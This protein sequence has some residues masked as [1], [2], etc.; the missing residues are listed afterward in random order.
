MNAVALVDC[1]NFFVSCER[2][3]R[4]ELIGRPVVVLSGNDGCVISRSQEAKA[5]G[6]PMGVPFFE[7]RALAAEHDIVILSGN[8]ELYGD[9]S[10][11]VMMTLAD[12]SPE[13]EI[14][15]IDE[16]FLTLPAGPE[17]LPVAVR[18][19]ETVRCWVGIP[20]SVGLAPTKVLAKLASERAKSGGGVF[21]LLETSERER[22][23]AAT[24]VGEVWGIGKRLDE[25]LASYGLRTVA[26]LCAVPDRTLQ[27]ILGVGGLKLVWELRGTPCLALEDCPR[28]RKT[29]TCSRSF[30]SPVGTEESLL[31]AV[32][33]F[34]ASAAERMRRQDL[35]AGGLTVW[36]EW[37]EEGRLLS[38][39]RSAELEPTA[40]TRLLV[41]RAKSL[42]E[43]MFVEG[44]RYKKAGVT[45]LGLEAGLSAQ[46]EFFDDGSADRARRLMKAVDGLNGAF[47]SGTLKPAAALRDAWKP[48][49]QLRSPCWTTRWKDLPA[50]TACG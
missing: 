34:T 42:A 13:M 9:F 20:V 45:L 36:T 17:L 8:H 40:D 49:S 32:A 26:E 18:L 24:P 35:R 47:G 43:L 7:V 21:S 12:F 16:A 29:V 23:L 39:S 19:R 41:A 15:S 27:R 30:G 1:N 38:D 22:V 44:R 2:V 33:S 6:V 25:R 14:Y 46:R 10:R 5:L 3:F 4:P 37:R 11:R 28:P 31:S 48:R 50:V